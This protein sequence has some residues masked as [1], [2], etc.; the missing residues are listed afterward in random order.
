MVS[1]C[2]AACLQIG[3]AQD[4]GPGSGRDDQRALRGVL[5]I[6]SQ[7]HSAKPSVLLAVAASLVLPGLGELYA[8]NFDTGRYFMIAEGVLWMGYG[9]TVFR[10]DWIREDARLFAA[11]RAGASFVGKDGKFEV[12]IGNFMNTDQYNEQKLRNREFDLLYRSSDFHWEWRSVDDRVRFR[13]LRIQ[14]EEWKQASRFV[15]AALVVNR[16]ISAFSAGRAASR[17]DDQ[18]WEFDARP[19]GEFLLKSEGVTLQIRRFL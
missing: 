16:V 13:S 11:E 4:F 9:G 5:S 3:A 19:V 12:N 17:S 10:S 8:G 1:C 7:G 2:I 14:S 18:A 15:V 6:P